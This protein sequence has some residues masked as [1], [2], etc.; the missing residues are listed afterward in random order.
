MAKIYIV[1]HKNPVTVSKSV[2]KKVA[3]IK[4]NP[5]IMPGHVIDLPEMVI[6]KREIKSVIIED[7]DDNATDSLGERMKENDT[8]YAM[9]RIEYE[10][11][12]KQRCLA[13]WNDKAKSTS[14][15]EM[16]YTGCT[17]EFPPEQFVIEVMRRQ[18][19]YFKVYPRHPYAAINVSDLI[20]KHSFGE[21]SIARVMPGASV[22]KAYAIISEALETAKELG[23]VS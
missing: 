17:G 11:S 4:A 15:W 19:E 7:S 16:V 13:Q 3:E 8:Y 5:E 12:I 20:P 14:L 1:G 10:G 22:R 21:D 23:Y 6:E 18:A 2:A 9:V